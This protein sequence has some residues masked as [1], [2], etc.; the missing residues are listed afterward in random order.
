MLV[1]NVQKMVRWVRWHCPTDTGFEIKT[2]EIWGRAR[3]LSVTETPF[4]PSYVKR[5]NVTRW[6]Q[7]YIIPLPHTSFCETWWRTRWKQGYIITLSHTSFYEP[8][9]TVSRP[10]WIGSTRSVCVYKDF[11]SVLYTHTPSAADSLRPRDG[12]QCYEPAR[13]K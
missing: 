8:L 3:Y 4:K 7:G 1:H 2:L 11:I 10:K 5:C 9:G 6:K 12:T 13:W